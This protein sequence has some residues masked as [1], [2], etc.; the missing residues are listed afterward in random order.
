VDAVLAAVIVAGVLVA[1]GAFVLGGPAARPAV[2]ATASASTTAPPAPSSAAATPAAPI[3]PTRARLCTFLTPADFAAV[4]VPSPALTPFFGPRATKPLPGQLTCAGG[5][6]T[7]YATFW[8]NDA[9]FEHQLF[10]NDRKRYVD[11]GWVL[12][13]LAPA[14]AVE[15]FWI[16]EDKLPT[17]PLTPDHQAEAWGHTATYSWYLEIP[18]ST[19]DAGE[20]LQQLAALLMARVAQLGYA[21][22]SPTDGMS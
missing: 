19:P 7:G 8:S 22:K 9:T 3:R 13:P 16:A 4:G 11:A 5:L 2:A 12:R 15:A 14:G 17:V 10:V 20:K 21:R 6:S 18:R 1:T